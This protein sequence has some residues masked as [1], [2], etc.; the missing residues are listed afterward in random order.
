MERRL[1]RGL[2]SLLGRDETG[3]DGASPGL[4]VE[5]I[6]P[7]PNQPRKAFD[8]ERL[9]ELRHSIEAH[10]VLHP[11]CVRAV[12]GGY[13]IIAGERRWRAARLAGLATIPAVVR[14]DVDDGAM[15]ELALV[16]NV[17]RQDLNAIEKARGYREMMDRLGLT[18][19]Q[20]A[21]RVGLQRAS[22]ANHLRLLELPTELQEAVAARVITM[23]HARAF[24]GL[25]DAKAMG[26]LLRL[27]LRHDLSVRELERRVR[28]ASQE[29]NSADAPRKRGRRPTW[30]S[31][32]ESR[33]R[34]HLGTRVEIQNGK[35]FQGRIV[36]HYHDRAE[37]DRLAEFL[38]PRP[39]L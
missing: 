21:A 17:Q 4:P 38:G 11:I 22:V 2:E 14:P 37:L 10:G 9:E 28:K 26:K 32:L 5:Q 19:E 36:L 18:Q 39:E 33:M 31:E 16:E 1:G 30:A 12:R 20:V 6:R 24:L 27:T 35:E 29:S 23:G 7:N 3:R 8:S 13:E 34:E 15:L 25:Q